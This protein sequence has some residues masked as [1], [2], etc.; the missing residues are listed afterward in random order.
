MSDPR[1]D[2]LAALIVGYST[3]IAAGDRVILEA[4]PVA[5]PL[6]LALQRHILRA[7]GHPHLLATLPGQE[8]V[9]LA[10]ANDA[11]LDFVPTFQ[12]EA[13]Q[14][15]QARVRIHSASNTHDLG[16]ADEGRLAHRQKALRPI[17]QAQME[18]GAR[19]EL[20]WL[21]TLFPTQAYA[22]DAGMGLAD[23]EAMFYAACRVDS[24][25]ADPM[26]AW[27]AVRQTQASLIA[28]LTG[29]DRVEVRG[30][31]CDLSLSIQ[32]RTFVNACGIHNMPDGEIYTS[33]VEDSIQ[34]WVRYSYPTAWQGKEVEGVELRFEAGRVVQAKAQRNQA[35][36]DRILE[37]DA[38]ARHVGEFAI[39]TN[40][41][42]P[43]ATRQILLD[44][45]I[46]GTFHMAL[47]AGYP[48]TGSRNT[49]AIHWDMICDLR[50]ESEIRVDGEVV[51]RDGRFVP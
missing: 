49:S 14:T 20:R 12:L 43:R 17:L 24:P 39:G 33:P 30:P 29:H 34:G 35:F 6:V 2:R 7:G 3:R 27:E 1:V 42:L 8:A 13:Y 26:Q 50:R 38:G 36:L 15:F 31:D 18:R 37:T 51:Y 22:Q 11:Q 10:E 4:E 21:T 5:A 19:G 9:Y 44:E 23:Y 47:G 40:P 32:G 41:A 25:S 48:E 45:R 46:G 16:G 28:A